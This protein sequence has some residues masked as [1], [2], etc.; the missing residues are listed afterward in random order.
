[1]RDDIIK[2]VITTLIGAILAGLIAYLKQLKDKVKNN[3]KE[4]KDDEI[5]IR[6]AVK[7]LLRAELKRSCQNYIDIGS[8][9]SDE[10]EELEEAIR[11][12]EALDGNG[13]IH[14][15]WDCVQDLDIN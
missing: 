11:V 7:I 13:L 1:M 10:Y 3:I 12:Y 2:Y 6:E 14:K 4:N 15:L 9:S 5:A 8:I